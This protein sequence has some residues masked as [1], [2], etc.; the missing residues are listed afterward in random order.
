VLE[1]FY[2]YAREQVSLALT[3]IVGA[4]NLGIEEREEVREALN[5]YNAGADFPDVLIGLMN[6]RRGCERTRFPS[7]E[8][9]ATSRFSRVVK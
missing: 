9:P 2:G 6:L 7:I 5:Q 3:G 1:G 8:K 4:T